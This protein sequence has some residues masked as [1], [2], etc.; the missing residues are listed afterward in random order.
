MTGIKLGASVNAASPL[1]FPVI[2]KAI[3]YSV[4]VLHHAFQRKLWDVPGQEA[5]DAADITLLAGEYPEANIILA[6]LGGGGDWEYALKAVKPY[7]NIFVDIS[8]SGCD[9]GMIQRAYS[10][11]GAGRLL[12]G[13]DIDLCS[14]LGK[15]ESLD[16]PEEERELIAYKNAQEL[17]GERCAAEL[18]AELR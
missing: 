15:F 7:S 5:S 18:A 17:T 13:T 4:P 3:E 12:F 10:E 1:V 11:L 2:E 9:D 6:H 16:V 8:G 14:A